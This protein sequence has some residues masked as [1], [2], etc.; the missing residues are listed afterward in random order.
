MG[1]ALAAASGGEE[2]QAEG[3]REWSRTRFSVTAHRTV[4]CGWR[5]RGAAALP[6]VV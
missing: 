4:G 3:E 5:G 1:L 6:A 2:C